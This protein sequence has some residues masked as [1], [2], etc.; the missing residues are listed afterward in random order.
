MG[1][2][3]IKE[4]HNDKGLDIINL[5]GLVVEKYPDIKLKKLIGYYKAERL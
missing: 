2:W 5:L 1:S 4:L 3:E